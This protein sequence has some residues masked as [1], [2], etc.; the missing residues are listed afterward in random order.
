MGPKELNLT[1]YSDTGL[2][3]TFR[4]LGTDR[5]VKDLTT[6]AVH[7]SAVESVLDAAEAIVVTATI[8]APATGDIEVVIEPAAVLALLGASALKK[9]LIYTFMAKPFGTYKV[10]LWGGTLTLRR[11]AG[12][13]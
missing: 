10:R 6:W 12:R 4:V 11:G 5:A 13:W 8:P 3:E 2:R 9:D 7:F 1:A